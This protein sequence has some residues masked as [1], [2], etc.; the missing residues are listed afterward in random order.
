MK[1]KGYD[2]KF[3]ERCKNYLYNPGISVFN[4]ALL[5]NKNF[6]INSMHDP[7]EGGLNTGIAEMG[8]ASNLGVIINKNKIKILPEPLELSKIFK[9]DPLGTISSGSLLIS[10][11]K[12]FSLALI[13]LLKNNNI[14]AEIIGEFTN[15]KNNFL[16]IETNGRKES[17]NFSEIDEITKIF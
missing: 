17:L 13:E 6:H 11:N 2:S 8:I 12:K 14:F 16:M 10:I 7:T 9:I 15:K 5:A 3:I 1:E 4:E